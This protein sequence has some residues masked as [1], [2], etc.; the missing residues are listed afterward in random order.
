MILPPLTIREALAAHDDVS[1]M[2]GERDAAL[3]RGS[4]L[5][6]RKEGN[7]TFR[8]TSGERSEIQLPLPRADDYD[9]TIRLDPFPRPPA[10][11]LPTVQAFLNG[12]L[13]AIVPTHWD[14]ARVGAYD[15]HASKSLVHRGDNR[16][17]V[18]SSDPSRAIGVWYVRIRPMPAIVPKM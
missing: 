14:P 11:P 16:L 17:M 7:A 10:E 12:Q 5:P 1:I 6:A 15:L 9:L 2:A 3:F 8:L 13:V 18:K 4:W